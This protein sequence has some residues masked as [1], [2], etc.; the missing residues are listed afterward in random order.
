MSSDAFVRFK[1]KTIAFGPQI[2]DLAATKRDREFLDEVYLREMNFAAGGV[3]CA[4]WDGA[5]ILARFLRRIRN[6][7]AGRRVHEVGAGVGLP[8]IV[9]ARYAASCVLS[10]YIPSLVENLDYN[11]ALNGARRRV[12]EA[13]AAPD[14]PNAAALHGD[15]AEDVIEEYR[16]ALR[17]RVSHAATAAVLDWEEFPSLPECEQ[18]R[19]KCDIIIGSEVTYSQIQSA[20]IPALF[21]L[22]DATLSADGVFYTIQSVNRETHGFVCAQMRA[23]G[24]DVAAV[25]VPKEEAAAETTGQITENYAYYT[26]RRPNSSF[27]VMGLEVG[28]TLIEDDDAFAVLCAP[29]PELDKSIIA[30]ALA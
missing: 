5:I 7:L 22:V 27:P 19:F 9:A 23:R 29:P 26:F 13:P 16:G 24:F 4:A 14:T 15:A 1:R 28:G 8:G 10:D 25:A 12:D 2:G 3:G 11:I 21:A 30:S 20:G 6:T 17:Q 18:E